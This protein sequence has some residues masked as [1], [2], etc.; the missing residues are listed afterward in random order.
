[1]TKGIIPYFLMRMVLV[2]LN[3]KRM[4]KENLLGLGRGDVVFKPVFFAVALI[5]IKSC[6]VSQNIQI[7]YLH[8]LCIF[9]VWTNVKV[10][11]PDLN[12]NKLFLLSCSFVVFVAKKIIQ[13]S[14]AP[15]Q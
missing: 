7:F 13:E 2:V 3:Y 6:A 8:I 5:P 14:Q 10:F 1:M 12:L 15:V 11:S 4:V 9:L